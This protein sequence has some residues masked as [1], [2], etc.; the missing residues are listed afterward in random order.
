[1]VLDYYISKALNKPLKLS[2]Y[3]ILLNKQ[4]QLKN[5]D[6][7]DEQLISS[8]IAIGKNFLHL[9]NYNAHFVYNFRDHK[10]LLKKNKK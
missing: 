8:I 6:K 3:E 5:L 10:K 2:D 9:G 7:H 1:M 4:V